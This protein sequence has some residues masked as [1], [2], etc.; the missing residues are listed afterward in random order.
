M[1]ALATQTDLPDW[2]VDDKP[3]HAALDDLGIEHE[4]VAWD[5]ASADWSRYEGVVI[6]TTWDYT[7]R[8]DAFV[9]WAESV[10]NVSSLQNPSR[11]V[12]WNTR[13]TYLRDLESA[14]IPIVPTEWVLPGESGDIEEILERRGWDRGFMKPVIGS[15]AKGTLR[16]DRADL[17]A[18]QSHLDGLVEQSGAMVQPYL[19]SVER[20]GEFS[21][22]VFDGEASHAVR[23]VPVPGDYRVQDDFG[24]SDEP[25]DASAAERELARRAVAD[26]GFEDLLYARVD[27]L[28]DDA[29]QPQLVELELVEPSLFFRH[30]PR[31]AIRFAEAVRARFG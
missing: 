6:R 13:K 31:S 29:G 4:S 21:I 16:F 24:A 7:A 14:G 18:A 5:D 27:F 28:R 3:F 25:H 2:E 30:D 20:E 10:E 9:A 26:C 17:A 19:A 11:V 15:T 22:I 1:I 23:K 12:R 8:C